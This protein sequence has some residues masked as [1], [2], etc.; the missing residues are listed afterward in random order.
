MMPLP[1]DKKAL[2]CRWVYKI[3]RD[4]HV[5]VEQYKSRVVAKGFLQRNGM[6]GGLSSEDVF[7]P[8]SNMNTLRVL[9]SLAAQEDYEAHQLDVKTAF[10]NGDLTQD[11][12]DCLVVGNAAGVQFAK[13]A[14]KALFDIKDIGPVCLFWGSM[15][16]VIELHASC[17]LDSPAMLILCLRT[18]A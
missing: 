3:K 10:L 7:A 14:I 1:D 13:D 8:A 2:P 18:L 5:C 12:D 16:F 15:L 4:E 9:L 17:G 6:S 11:V